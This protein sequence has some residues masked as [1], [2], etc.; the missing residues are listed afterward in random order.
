MPPFREG[1]DHKV[2]LVQGANLVN[3]RPYRYAKKDIIDKMLQEYLKYGVIQ[4]S[5][6][7]VV[8]VEKTNGLGDCV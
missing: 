6:N 5:I 1:H 4:N 3:K 2:P 8:L 7:P